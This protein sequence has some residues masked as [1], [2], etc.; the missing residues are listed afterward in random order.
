MLLQV[1]VSFP[2]PPALCFVVFDFLLVSFFL[3]RKLSP[4]PFL[5]LL[6]P[7]PLCVCNVAMIILLI[8]SSVVAWSSL[9]IQL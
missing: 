9:R 5:P 7:S 2:V 6:P 8:V 1:V 4:P 3:P